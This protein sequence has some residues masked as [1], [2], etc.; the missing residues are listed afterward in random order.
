MVRRKILPI[1]SL[2]LRDFPALPS[3]RF[4]DG[5]PAS[6]YAESDL[7]WDAVVIELLR[8]KAFGKLV[9]SNALHVDAIG[10]IIVQL[11]SI[12]RLFDTL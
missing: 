3:S 11:H 6:F 9:A 12:C 4:P 1:I 7:K 8:T 5:T 10:D 2:Q